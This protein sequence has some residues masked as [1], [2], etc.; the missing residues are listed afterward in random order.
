MLH[1]KSTKIKNE[2]LTLITE[3]SKFSRYMISLKKQQQK[4]THK[5]T[6]TE[7]PKTKAKIKTKT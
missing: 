3:F 1:R 5:K 2:L 6:Q 4:Y 7:N